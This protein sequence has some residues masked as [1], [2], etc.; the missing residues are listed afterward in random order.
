G[1]HPPQERSGMISLSVGHHPIIVTYFEAGGGNL[2][3]VL[4]Q[5][6]GIS[7]RP[8]P[9]SVLKGNRPPIA[10]AG[11]DQT[12]SENTM[13][14][15]DGAA[16]SDPD[17]LILKYEW[18]FESDGAY[19]YQ[20]TQGDAPDGSFDGQTDHAYLDDGEYIATLRVTDD[21]SSVA[22]DNAIITVENV[23][24]TLSSLAAS[25]VDEG[26]TSA[27]SGI[28]FDPGILDTFTLSVDWGNGSPVE[29][30]SYPAG[31]TAFSE[32]HQYLDDNPSGTLSDPYTITVTVTDD[33][34]ESE[35]A[36]TQLTVQNVAPTL[37]SLVASD[38]DEGGTSALSGIIFDPGILDTFTLSVDW[39]DG[40]PVE[41]FSYPAGTTAFS[42]THQYLD[43]NPS[44][45]LSDPYTITVTVTDDDTDSE[46]ATTQLT[47]QNVAPFIEAGPDQTVNLGETVYVNAE[48]TDPG[49]LDTHTATISWDDVSSE[50]GTVI[51]SGGSGNVTG[52]HMYTWPGSYVVTV[53]VNDDDGGVSSGNFTCDV[54]P[55]PK[56]MV[57]TVSDDV[58]DMDLPE[59][60]ENSLTTSLDTAMKILSDSNQKNDVAAINALE[61]FINKI[62][63]QRGKKIVEDVANE[64][65]A[66]AQEIIVL[67]SGG[68]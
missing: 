40:S 34:T 15:L 35:T 67:L 39:G 17:G 13:I 8:I 37:S 56:T 25:D 51:E 9:D 38:V 23:A 65:I 60:T 19:D 14:T 50:A 54:L 28:I 30:F 44:G 43:D 2:L 59:G 47:V 7:K 62:E 57:E 53:E 49:S 45:T 42:E 41:S 32:T 52:S 16:S 5:G 64:L 12:T 22:T 58:E 55:V 66:K 61:A 48:F 10:D 4:Y 26:G 33:D 24:P 46:T 20:E 18:D 29:S 21:D 1:L 27:L 68:T 11:P 6:P 63:A 3:D 31:T 36:T